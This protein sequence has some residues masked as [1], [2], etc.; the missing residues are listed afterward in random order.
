MSTFEKLKP[1]NPMFESYS[2]EKK[3]EIKESAEKKAIREAKSIV[4]KALGINFS[5]VAPQFKIL[6]A[7]VEKWEGMAAAGQTPNP[8]SLA[9]RPSKKDNPKGSFM[10]GPQRRKVPKGEKSV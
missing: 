5:K 6:E 3:V 2:F 8:G 7:A 1:Y 9:N 4:A 10:V